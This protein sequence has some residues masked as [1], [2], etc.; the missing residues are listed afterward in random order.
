MRRIEVRTDDMLIVRGVN[1]F[2]AQVEAVLRQV[3]GRQAPRHQIVIE[4]KH[5]LDEATVLV[6]VSQS[7]FFDE[8]RLQAEF[9]ETLK[10]RLASELGVSLEVKLVQRNTMDGVAGRGHV[11]DLRGAPSPGGDGA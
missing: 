9:R 4:R 1:L 8:V 3:D 5:A 10:R 11:V 2:P 6:E 7:V